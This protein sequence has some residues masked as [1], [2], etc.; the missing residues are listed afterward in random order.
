MTCESLILYIY[1]LTHTHAHVLQ[2]YYALALLD[3]GFSPS[4]AREQLDA[5]EGKVGESLREFCVSYVLCVVWLVF[6]C[7]LYICIYTCV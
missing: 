5:Y 4:M 2:V 1:A 7:W 6:V 3:N